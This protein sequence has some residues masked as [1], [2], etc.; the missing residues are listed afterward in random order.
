MA[1]YERRI[2]SALDRI[3]RDIEALERVVAAPDPAAEGAVAVPGGTAAPA[4]AAALAEERAAEQVAEHIAEQ[5]EE[6]G[7]LRAALEAER[8]TNAQLVERVR[9]IKD[10]QET[11]VGALERRVARLT[12]Q[13][14][15]ATGELHKLRR[16][17]QQLRDT[18][19]SLRRAAVE[20]MSDPKLINRA[21]LTELEA[22]SAVRAA[23]AAELDGILAEL[24]PLLEGVDDA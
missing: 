13:L 24:K 8:G 18:S 10:K 11:M 4:D 22:L 17:N 5:A 6:L 12:E 7:A 14:D 1:E 16:V 15:T 23:E 3:G 2:A 9:A 19:E 21:M 20:G